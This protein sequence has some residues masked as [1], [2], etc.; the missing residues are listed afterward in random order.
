[1]SFKFNNWT[2]AC[3]CPHKSFN[4]VNSSFYHKA[5]RVVLLLMISCVCTSEDK[6]NGGL[7]VTVQWA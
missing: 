6:M 2:Q 7:L 1:M 4:A 5:Y 3:S